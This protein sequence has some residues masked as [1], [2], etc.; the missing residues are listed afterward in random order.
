MKRYV[1]GLIAFTVHPK[2]WNP[3]AGMDVFNLEAAELFPTQVM[4]E[5]R[6]EQS[7]VAKALILQNSAQRG[8]ESQRPTSNR[9]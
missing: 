1:A 5:Q 9:S 6:G 7:A 8:I 2:V 4:V 3:A